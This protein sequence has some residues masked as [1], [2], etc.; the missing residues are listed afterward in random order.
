M[1][2]AQCNRCHTMVEFQDVSPDYYAYC[3][4]PDEDLFYFEIEFIEE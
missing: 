3:P 4:T 1:A 2:I